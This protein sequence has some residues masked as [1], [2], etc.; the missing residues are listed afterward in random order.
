[1]LAMIV[2]SIVYDGAPVVFKTSNEP[3]GENAI[4]KLSNDRMFMRYLA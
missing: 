3:D 1:M 2:V 4:R